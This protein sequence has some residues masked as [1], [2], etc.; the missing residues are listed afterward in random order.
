MELKATITKYKV[1]LTYS[2]DSVNER[3]LGIE[4]KYTESKDIVGD[5]GIEKRRFIDEL[6][7]KLAS[8]NYNNLEY[9][10]DNKEPFYF[11]L[12]ITNI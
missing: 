6:A 4:N 3:N 11:K 5:I 9:A 8:I 1:E 2:N 12:I 7:S 10:K